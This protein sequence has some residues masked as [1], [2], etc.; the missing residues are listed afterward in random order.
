MEDNNTQTYTL[1]TETIS[2]IAQ[3]LQMSMLTGTD[4]YD[5]LRTLQL[6]DKEGSLHV[7]PEFQQRLTDEI[8]RLSAQVETLSA[9]QLQFGFQKMS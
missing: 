4:L 5:H 8:A 1:S 6:V 2:T 7:S 9:A 3:L